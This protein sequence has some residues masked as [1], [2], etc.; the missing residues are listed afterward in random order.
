MPY[1]KN[2]APGTLHDGIWQEWFITIG[3]MIDP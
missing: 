1:R 2:D 3:V